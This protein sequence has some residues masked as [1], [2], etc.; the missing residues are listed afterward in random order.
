[1]DIEKIKKI[2]KNN[3]ILENPTYRGMTWYEVQ[4]IDHLQAFANE[5]IEEVAMHMDD[6]FSKY[7]AEEIRKLK[8]GG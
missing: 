1:M 2:A 6:K 3:H 7:A 8:D 5:V 4:H